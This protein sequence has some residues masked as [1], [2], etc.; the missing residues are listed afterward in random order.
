MKEI[1]EYAEQIRNTPYKYKKA[2]FIVHL[3][4]VPCPK[5]VSDELSLDRGSSLSA[6]NA[7]AIAQRIKLETVGKNGRWG[8]QKSKSNQH[9]TANN[10]HRRIQVTMSYIGADKFFSLGDIEMPIL[11]HSTSWW[12]SWPLLWWTKRVCR[13]NILVRRGHALITV[14][15]ITY[16]LKCE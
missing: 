6:F 8:S 4:M 10:F 5:F 16:F 1:L 9:V 13:L 3:N 2:S 12:N 11:L 15:D 7:I 14:L